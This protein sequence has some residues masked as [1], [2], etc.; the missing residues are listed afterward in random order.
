MIFFLKKNRRMGIL[1]AEI[2]LSLLAGK[3]TNFPTDVIKKQKLKNGRMRVRSTRIFSKFFG[4]KIEN[5]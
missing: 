3:L 5:F 4:G 1:R 2:F